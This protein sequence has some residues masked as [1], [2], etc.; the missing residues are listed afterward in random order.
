[1]IDASKMNIGDSVPFGDG[2]WND[3]KRD[4]LSTINE[5]ANTQEP[6]WQFQV[7]RSEIGNRSHNPPSKDKYILTRLR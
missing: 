2:D 5:F 7:D 3:A 4:L 1:M 6:R